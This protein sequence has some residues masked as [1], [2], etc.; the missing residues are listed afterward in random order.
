VV[1]AT[2]P[3]TWFFLQGE[4]VYHYDIQSTPTNLFVFDTTDDLPRWIGAATLTDGLMDGIPSRVVMKDGLV[5]IATQNKGIQVVDLENAKAGFPETG[6]PEGD[7]ER[8]FSIF[9]DGINREAVKINVPIMEP[10]TANPG[11]LNAY[12]LPLTDLKVEDYVVAGESKRLVVATGPRKEVTLVVVDPIFGETLW[13]GPLT[14]ATGT[15]EWGAAIA[16]AALDDRQLVLVGGFGGSGQSSG[17]LAVVDMSPLATSAGAAPN[18]LAMIA[19]PHAVGDIVVDGTT[20]IVAGWAGADGGSGPATLVDLTEPTSPRIVGSMTGV[21]SRL[22]LAGSVLL[23]TERSFIKGLPT[24]LGGVRTTALATVAVIRQITPSAIVTEGAAD[25]TESDVDIEAAVV[26]ST[27]EIR[28]AE[29]RILRNG[30]V[31]ETLPAAISGSLAR[32]VWPARRTVDR[33][34]VYTAVAAIDKDGD[35]PLTSVPVQVPLVQ[36]TFIDRRGQETFAPPTSDPQPTVVLD[37]VQPSHIVV[38][39]GGTQAQVRLSG[40]VTDPLADIVAERAADIREV[41][42]RGQAYPVTRVH[43]PATPARPYASKGRFNFTITIPLQNG[44]NTVVVQAV[45]AV[46]AKGHD[47]VSFVVLQ[48]RSTNDTTPTVSTFAPKFLDPFTVQAAAPDAAGRLAILLHQGFGPAD[49][50]TRLVHDAPNT[51][52]YSG[53]SQRFGIARV[54]LDAPLAGVDPAVREVVTGRIYSSALSIAGEPLEFVETGA[55]SGLFRS[56]ARRLPTND[57]VT[58]ALTEL[59]RADV[60]DTV[61]VELEQTAGKMSG[62]LTETGTGTNVFTGV[63]DGIGAMT[64]ELRAIAQDNAPTR[65]LHG[66]VTNSTLTLESFYMAVTESSAGTLQF[67]TQRLATGTVGYFT[68]TTNAA[69]ILAVENN[70]GSTSAVVEPVWLAVKG[71]PGIPADPR[72]KL[73]D[74]DLEL[75]A[76]PTGTEPTGPRARRLIRSKEPVIFVRDPK[77][78]SKRNVVRAAVDP[79]PADP[80]ELAPVPHR[81]EYEDV[82]HALR[83]KRHTGSAML[84]RVSIMRGSVTDVFST[85]IVDS[86]AQWGI[87]NITIEPATGVTIERTALVPIPVGGWQIK[88]GLK[89]TVA[90]DAPL[91]ERSLVYHFSNNTTKRFDNVISVSGGRVVVFAIDGLA[92]AQFDE[93]IRATG[94]EWDTGKGTTA[95]NRIFVGTPTRGRSIIKEAV[96]SFPPIT[97]T[98]WASIFSGQPPAVTGVPGNN[99]MNRQVATG[100]AF[101]QGLGQ[102]ER[103]RTLDIFFSEDAYNRHHPVPFIYDTLRERGMRSI[104]INQQAGLGQSTRGMGLTENGPD[105]LRWPRSMLADGAEYLYANK[106]GD[107]RDEAKEMDE[108][109]EEMAF[110]EIKRLN[111]QFE[112][113]VIY[114][115]GLDHLIHGAGGSAQTSRTYFN[116]YLHGTINRIFKE[117]GPLRDSTVFGIVSDHGHYDTDLERAIDFTKQGAEVR[118][119]KTMHDVL[120]LRSDI[121]ARADF[122]EPANV[123]F[124]PQFGIAHVYVAGTRAGDWAKPARVADLEEIV[125]SLYETYIAPFG[126]D[127]PNRP[128]ADIL[129]RKPGSAT[130]F[131]GSAYWVVPRN[132]VPGAGLEGQLVEVSTLQ[133]LG[134]GP[135]AFNEGETWAYDDAARRVAEFVSPNTGDIVL[136][137]NGPAGFQFGG[138]YLAQHG[139]LAVAD[140]RV[141][142]AFGYPGGS[143]NDTLL[144]KLTQFLGA[145]PDPIRTLVEAAALEVFFLGGRTPATIPR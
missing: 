105:G 74:V 59:P 88:Q 62:T 33:K 98:R 130:S 37:P 83:L 35:R 63:V 122:D 108:G 12:H 58:F 49:D 25:V 40:N 127:W 121:R 66:F 2:A 6:V 145:L 109:G 104:V 77:G 118:T 16:T 100:G 107:A 117:L 34:A 1:V 3:R 134:Y 15:L 96:T 23:S 82:V 95:F 76:Q 67:K 112:L 44:R 80:I 72:V 110:S 60:A 30:T 97:F 19:L 18:V 119:T 47:S 38:L 131:D 84:S 111:G 29:I 102:N 91:G 8:N 101:D 53:T 79:E 92:K 21:G 128:V 51:L 22:A 45:N 126:D 89:F 28:T 144:D 31:I 78:F 27:Y 43:E 106:M 113:M 124:N 48:S 138:A 93:A 115:P 9:K 86:F 50:A 17:M 39:A 52:T 143:R 137:A 14:H 71:L 114:L 64:F 75:T 36:I 85:F 70:P 90:A 140:S 133:G 55:A 24:P 136:L 4:L 11:D 142:V 26:P 135:G 129:V 139:S 10:K 99:W 81:I 116:E 7:Y 103:D 32:A 13:R 42:A 61:R 46:G 57:V 123:I 20:A 5:Y 73:N 87:E 41:T 54:V 120:Q 69:S 125:D 94:P 141:P 65:T 68:A 56:V 132:Y